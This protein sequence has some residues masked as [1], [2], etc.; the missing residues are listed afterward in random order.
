MV[1]LM[2]VLG[3]VLSLVA[4]SG[5][6]RTD[7]LS[8]AEEQALQD[9]VDAAEAARIKAEEEKAQADDEKAAALERE[10]IAEQE[11]ERQRQLAE[12]ARQRAEDAKREADKQKEQAEKA[13]L[14]TLQAESGVAITGL[15]LTPLPLTLAADDVKPKYRAPALVTPTDVTFTSPRRSSA[16][17]W[18]KTTASNQGQDYQDTIVVYSDVENADSVP[19]LEVPVYASDFGTDAKIGDTYLVIEFNN[20]TNNTHKNRIASSLFPINGLERSFDRPNDSTPDDNNVDMDQT[21]LIRGTFDGV[22]G[23]YQCTGSACTVDHD[24]AGYLFDAGTWTFRTSKNA[25]V[26]VPDT[27]FMYFGWWRR[28]TNAAGTFSYGTFSNAGMTPATTDFDNLQGSA[29]YE[30]SAIGQYAIYQP[31]STQSNHG[32]F[33]ATARFRANFTDNMLSGSVSGFDVSPGWSLTLKES[34]MNGGTVATPNAT[35]PST[36]SWTFDG[37]TRDGGHWDGTFHSAIDPYVGDVPDGLTGKFSAT[38][39]DVGRLVG[40]YGAHRE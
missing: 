12:D 29:T 20:T 40:A 6:S 24:G 8:K 14:E 16:G 30:G 23:H 5:G 34:S 15:R 13:R 35:D 7:G 37:N 1:R 11:Q 18:D 33:K 38:Y 19:F 39:G 17:A 9:R 10:R 3:L 4:C 2:L 36:V 21:A 27:E 31:L 22:G 26:G 25:K 28:K 32:E